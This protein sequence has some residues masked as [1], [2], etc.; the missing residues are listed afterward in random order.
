M[1]KIL[2]LLL[3]LSAAAGCRR[4]SGTTTDNLPQAPDYSQQAAWFDAG[5][6]GDKAYDVFYI[7]PTCVFDWQDESGTTQHHMDAANPSHRAAV[8]GP[9]RL[10]HGIFADEANFFAPYYRQI[11]IESWMEDDS[12]IEARFRTAFDDI[13]ASFRYYTDHL[14]QGRPFILA[15][16][17]QGGKAVIELLKR[18]MDERL[19]DR[20]IAA[21]PLGYPVREQDTSAYLIPAHDADGT[22]HFV[23]FNSVSAPDRL[24][25]LLSGSRAAINPMSWSTDTIVAPA[26]LHAGYVMMDSHGNITDERAGMVSARLDS[27]T[28]ALVISGIDPM[29]YY[30][31][32]LS[33]LFPPGNYHVAELNFFYRNLQQNVKERAA[34]F[35]TQQQ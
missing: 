2:I 10:A 12:V 1:K 3:A 26:T 14:N 6:R 19:Y 5:D 25:P 23:T 7:V 24:T 13:A 28:K 17:S 27:A 21:Y 31:P 16:H 8:E 18:C 15:G 34:A 32:A 9:L 35:F 29:D 22:G 30:V 4:H 11:T 33:G 20:M